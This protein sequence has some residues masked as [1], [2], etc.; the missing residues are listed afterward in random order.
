MSI[1]GRNAEPLTYLDAVPDAEGGTTVRLA[2]GREFLDV[3]TA[4]PEKDIDRLRTGWLCI[5][6]GEPQSE[7]FPEVCESTLPN[8]FRWCNFPIRLKQAAEFAVMF[9][10]TVQIGSRVK[11]ADEIERMREFDEYEARTGIKIPDSVRNKTGE[12]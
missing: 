7:A 6:C 3:N 10:G 5:R 8:G 2:D 12:L 1:P 11:V 4:H 9:K